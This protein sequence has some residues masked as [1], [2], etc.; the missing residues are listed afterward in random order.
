MVIYIWFIMYYVAPNIKTAPELHTNKFMAD[1]WNDIND[2]NKKTEWHSVVAKIQNNK[3]NK[4][5]AAIKIRVRRDE[6]LR[7]VAAI[8]SNGKNNF[9]ATWTVACV[10]GW[11][12]MSNNTIFPDMTWLR[13]SFL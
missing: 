12:P 1:D 4:I 3:K 8:K 5:L 6:R 13:D 7:I 2:R 9:F 11:R 10:I